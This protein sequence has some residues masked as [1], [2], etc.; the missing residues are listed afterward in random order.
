M[1]GK[2]GRVKNRETGQWFSSPEEAARAATLTASAESPTTPEMPPEE[3]QLNMNDAREIW[4]QTR[5]G[6]I[7]KLREQPAIN[8]E[9][10]RQQ[11]SPD[12]LPLPGFPKFSRTIE[13]AEIPDPNAPESVPVPASAPPATPVRDTARRAEPVVE[14]RLSADEWRQVDTSVS[15]FRNMYKPAL[16]GERKGPIAI[17]RFLEA[18]HAMPAQVINAVITDISSRGEGYPSKGMLEAA[19][20]NRYMYDYNFSARDSLNTGEGANTYVAADA[21]ADETPEQRALRQR[22]A[23]MLARLDATP[24][25]PGEATAPTREAATPV[26]ETQEQRNERTRKMLARLG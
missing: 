3:V 18:T 22:T 4:Y 12:S 23:Q 13:D 6:E 14:E 24:R 1:D 20:L 11:I 25:V 8:D 16:P 7:V 19:N 2:I 15:Y 10:D 9:R 26:A 21:P 5:S 17:T